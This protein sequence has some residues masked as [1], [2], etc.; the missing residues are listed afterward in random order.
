M[1]I[2]RCKQLPLKFPF[3]IYFLN[4]KKSKYIAL[5]TVLLILIVSGIYLILSGKLNNKKIPDYYE[6]SVFVKP[7]EYK[8]ATSS[9]SV[10]F[11]KLPILMYHYVENV[12][13]KND[14]LRIKL[15]I[16]PAN[17]DLQLKSLTEASYESLF[18]KDIPKIIRNPSGASDKK[19]IFLTF[20]DGYEDFYTSAFPVLKKYG[21]K[22]TLYIVNNFI[23]KI[24][25]LNEKE[26]KEI[27]SSG[28]VEIGSHTLDH[29]AL[30][31][32]PELTA[33]KEIFGSKKQLEDKFGIKI[34]TFAYPYGS[35]DPRA[36]NLVK[37]A[38]YKAAVSVIPGVMQSEENLYY[39]SRWRAG[40]F[41]GIS[42]VKRIEALNK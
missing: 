7:E 14:T 24:G 22:G 6:P 36:E 42:I 10:R 31:K 39:L 19:K 4:T 12:A 33:K 17:L 21:M 11:I 27:I 16:T 40:R 1:N 32:L 2:K 9:S 29:L 35:F 37:E 15:D 13:D 38:G 20:D 18:I 3:V 30:K 5:L 28:L 25:Y 26:L 41:P 8:S 23:G 34:E